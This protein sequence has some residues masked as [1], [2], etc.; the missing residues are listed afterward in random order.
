MIENI[1]TSWMDYATYMGSKV[2]DKNDCFFIINNNSTISCDFSNSIVYLDKKN[3]LDTNCRNT[4]KIRSIQTYTII[5]NDQIP[6][7]DVTSEKVA[8]LMVL[9]QDNFKKITNTAD[10]P[11]LIIKELT[12]NELGAFI[13]IVFDAFDYD[14]KN[15]AES[16]Q[17]YQIGFKSGMVRFY[18][19]IKEK[20]LVS[21]VLVHR[22]RNNSLYGLEL[23]ST[24]KQFQGKGYSKIL[25]THVMEQLFLS[26]PEAIWLFSIK[27]SIAES[28][29]KK[30][31]FLPL[32]RILISKL[33]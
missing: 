25:L 21:V 10:F 17:F 2:Y 18:G 4:F 15:I 16:L 14:K 11:D 26:S 20:T 12:I 33:Q 30:I 19:L 9:K 32:G 31:G 27:G 3:L 13:D 24:S 22:S 1:L 28:L 7:S 29:Y 5:K 8:S 6:V 23:V